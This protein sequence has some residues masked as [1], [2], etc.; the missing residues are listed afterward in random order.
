MAYILTANAHKYFQIKS[1][2]FMLDRDPQCAE[3]YTILILKGTVTRSCE[4][5]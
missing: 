4:M 5:S 2:K 1:A 3:T